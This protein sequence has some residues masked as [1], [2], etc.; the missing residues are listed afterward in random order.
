MSITSFDWTWSEWESAQ[1]PNPVNKSCPA[2]WYLTWNTL[3]IPDDIVRAAHEFVRASYTTLHRLGIIT[4]IYSYLT[5]MTGQLHILTSHVMKLLRGIGS[6]ASWKMISELVGTNTGLKYNQMPRRS[7]TFNPC[8]MCR[9]VSPSWK[10]EETL[11][12]GFRREL[13]IWGLWFQFSLLDAFFKTKDFGEHARYS[14][15]NR[16]FD[17][18]SLSSHL[19]LCCCLFLPFAC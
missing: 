4:D 6:I 9:H 19:V 2:G 11:K 8:S 12:Y 18:S 17:I 16:I 1:K 14:N 13:T 10:W 3:R 5:H 15:Q 7:H